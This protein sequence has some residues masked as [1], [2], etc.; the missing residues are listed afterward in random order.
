M[1]RSLVPF[2]GSLVLF[3]YSTTFAG[4]LDAHAGTNP[5]AVPT[6][7]CLGIYHKVDGKNKSQCEVTYREAGSGD[8]QAGLPLWFDERDSEFRGSIVG[9]TPDT[10]YEVV[11]RYGDDEQR[12]RAKTLSEEFPVGKTTYVNSGV[13]TETLHIT[14]SGTPDAWHLVTP[15]AGS[16]ATV[17]AE[18]RLDVN[19]LVEASYVIIRGLELQNAARDG[20]YIT[21]DFHDVVIE[22]CRITNWGR[23]GGS[24]SLGN[25]WMDDSAIKARKGSSGLIIQRNLIENPRGASNDWNTGHPNGPQGITL[26]DSRGRN[27]IRYN[28]I[29]STD[30]HGYNDAIGG[31]NNYSFEGNLNRDS[32]VY[33]NIIANVWD[34]AVE[35]EGANM[36]VR[37][38][39]NYIHY[40]HVHIATAATSKGPLYIFRNVLGL[41]RRA[42]GDPLGGAMIKVGDRDPYFGGRRYVFHNTALQPKG[43][44]RVFS[45]HPCT[46]TVTR[47]NIF[48][49]PGPF[50]RKQKPP[51]PSDLDHDLFTGLWIVTGYGDNVVRQKP[52]FVPSDT[53]EF[54]LA[55]TTT[56]IE[57]GKTTMQRGDKQLTVTDA[58]V[59]VR[60]PAIDAGI[61][62]PGFNDEFKGEGPD[63]G[64]FEIGNPPLRFGRRAV[65]PAVTAPWEQ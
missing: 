61:L 56:K 25:E 64:A 44:F 51:I 49:C 45:D 34:D 30:D 7:E 33:G 16:S 19:V 21:E 36:N 65:D 8:W 15:E 12:L 23:S 50:T 41:S 47:N 29:R 20:I 39:G 13:T 63:L 35:A 17:D 3:W 5:Y 31:A 59:D 18:N 6:F 54:F 24:I 2:W 26:I 37:I 1:K 40:T 48:D 60:N 55:P 32:D 38:W 9:L 58:V 27:V 11:L 4:G 28:E 43:P 53:R 14:E 62:L 10:E 22:D 46:N 52:A 42:Q 57:W